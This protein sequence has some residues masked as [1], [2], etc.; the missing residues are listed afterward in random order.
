MLSTVYFIDEQI[1]HRTVGFFWEDSESG[2]HNMVKLNGIFVGKYWDNDRI[3][4]S[5]RGNSTWD[6]GDEMN[7]LIISWSKRGING[8][9]IHHTIGICFLEYVTVRPY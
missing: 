4:P 5:R 6:N 8:L 1:Q 7:R 2:H 3:S 9:V